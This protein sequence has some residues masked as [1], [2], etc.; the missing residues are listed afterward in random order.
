M[1]PI[2][3]SAAKRIATEYGYDQVVI[4]ARKIGGPEDV[5]GEHCTT[6]GVNKEHCE[7]ASKIGDFIKYKIM[8]WENPND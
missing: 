5:H 6:Y 3:I 4:I 8:L 7:I 1:K 2:P